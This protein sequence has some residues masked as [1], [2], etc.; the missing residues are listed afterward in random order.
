M[1]DEGSLFHSDDPFDKGAYEG[2][3]IAGIEGDDAGMSHADL[4]KTC[5]MLREGRDIWKKE[6]TDAK[7]ELEKERTVL[8][9]RVRHLYRLLAWAAQDPTGPWPV[10]FTQRWVLNEIRCALGQ[11]SESD[12]WQPPFIA[13]LDNKMAQLEQELGAAKATIRNMAKFVRHPMW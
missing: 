7:A 9:E 6:A 11:T 8:A 2:H 4:V 1:N 12:F 10:K 13:E 3:I 5:K